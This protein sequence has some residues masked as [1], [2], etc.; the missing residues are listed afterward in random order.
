M[1]IELKLPDVGEGIARRGSRPVAVAEGAVVKEDD[2]LVEILTVQARTSKFPRRV[3]GTFLKILAAARADRERRGALASSSGA[4]AGCRRVYR[5]P[6]SSDRP[7]HPRR[8]ATE[9]GQGSSPKGPGAPGRGRA[10]HPRSSETAK[11][12]GWRWCAV[13]GTGPG[14][15]DHEEDVGERRRPKRCG[16]PRRLH[17][18][19]AGPPQRETTDDRA[20]DGR[21]KFRVPHALLVDEAASRVSWRSARRWRETASGRG[22]RITILPFIMKAVARGRSPGGTPPD[23]R[24]DRSPGGDRPQEEGRR[25]DGRG[26]RGR[27]WS[28]PIVRNADA[29]RSFE[30]GPGRSNG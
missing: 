4:R 1:P 11:D 5:V 28:V 23:A 7:T 10:R 21:R 2:P 17:V 24:C 22:V 15:P 3:S 13:P 12:L 29:N 27:S 16:V 6:A 26:R 9:P 8:E 14:W 18:G 30:A 25:R 19:G 20:E